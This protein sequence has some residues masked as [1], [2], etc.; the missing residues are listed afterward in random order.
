MLWFSGK[1]KKILNSKPSCT[2]TKCND[3]IN[4]SRHVTQPT[5]ETG[6]GLVTKAPRPMNGQ[7]FTT[8][9]KKFT[10]TSFTP[11]ESLWRVHTEDSI[12]INKNY[13]NDFYKWFRVQRQGKM[14]LR[15]GQKEKF[16][17]IY[18]MNTMVNYFSF[19]YN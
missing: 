3:L 2:T 9:G 17:M 7:L 18:Q 1:K 13:L 19:P 6:K 15:Y 11:I 5:G 14:N 12:F 16:F 8:F 10:K 4:H